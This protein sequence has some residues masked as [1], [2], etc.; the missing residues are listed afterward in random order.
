MTGG[1]AKSQLLLIWEATTFPAL[2]LVILG[3]SC[4]VEV[5]TAWIE[6]IPMLKSVY[7]ELGFIDAVI[8]YADLFALVSLVVLGTFILVLEAIA[9]AETK[10]HSIMT[11]IRTKRHERHLQ[12]L[13][14]RHERA[15]QKLG[16]RHELER[17]EREH[18]TR[19]RINQA[20][21]PQPKFPMRTGPDSTHIV[22]ISKKI[23][24]S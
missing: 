20:L 10:Y 22:S 18:V 24:A 19:G 11:T 12:R 9:K 13:E 16:H 21:A 23:S 1:S 15:K 14:R 4:I 7:A 8:R 5:A 2:L 3:I 17:L 6:K